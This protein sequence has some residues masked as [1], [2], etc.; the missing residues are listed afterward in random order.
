MFVEGARQAYA[1]CGSLPPHFGIHPNL[2][3]PLGNNLRQCAFMTIHMTM[4]YCVRT[5]G[6][7]ILSN[8]ERH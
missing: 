5:P 4:A 1:E 3:T 2:K 6:A 8:D 7:H